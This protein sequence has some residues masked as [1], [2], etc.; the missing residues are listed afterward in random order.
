MAHPLHNAALVRGAGSIRVVAAIHLLAGSSGCLDAPPEAPSDP[1]GPDGG[2]T[3][4]SVCGNSRVDVAYVSRFTVDPDAYGYAEMVS[5]GLVINSGAGFLDV[6]A[7]EVLDAYAA[8]DLSVLAFAAFDRGGPPIEPGEARGELS[9]SGRDMVLATLSEDWTDPNAP[10][11]SGALST[12][13]TAGTLQGTVVLG[14]G[15]HRVNLE[16]Q[17]DIGNLGRPGESLP[18]LANRASSTCVD[19]V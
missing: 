11:L 4:V 19:D 18:Q 16:M 3:L 17:L 5:V 2:G 14:L 6:A 8:D 7:L 13:R 15:P 1:G 10:E 9:A 12:V